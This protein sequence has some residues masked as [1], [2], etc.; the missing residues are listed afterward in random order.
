MKKL[1][2]K[3]REVIETVEAYATCVGIWTCDCESSKQSY[4]KTNDKVYIA[5]LLIG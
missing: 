1:G 4:A 2:K 5:A 3:N